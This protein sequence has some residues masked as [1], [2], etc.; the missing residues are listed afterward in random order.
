MKTME[1]EKTQRRNLILDLDGTLID[2][3]SPCGA[4]SALVLGRGAPS[5]CC[6]AKFG[7]LRIFKRPG[8]ETFLN[9]CFENFD[10]VGE[11][12]QDGRRYVDAARRAFRYLDAVIERVA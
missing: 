5:H 6:D 9:W 8:L 10:N 12:S 3:Q 1:Y 2:A 7:H 4:S 11:W